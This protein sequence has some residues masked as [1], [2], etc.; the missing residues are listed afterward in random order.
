MTK[1]GSRAGS[2]LQSRTFHVTEFRRQS[3]EGR[4]GYATF[5]TVGASAPVPAEAARHGWR[6]LAI[7]STLMGLVSIL[8]DLYLPPIPAMRRSCLGTVNTSE[9][10]EGRL[11]Q[12]ETTVDDE[13][14]T[15][16]IARILRK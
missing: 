1:P 3:G 10:A 7:L 6:V 11:V 2:I 14:S 15:G 5:A 4:N 9:S 8:T 16:N 12:P 13:L